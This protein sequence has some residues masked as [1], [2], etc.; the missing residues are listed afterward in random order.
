LPLPL[1]I[2]RLLRWQSSYQAAAFRRMHC[3][4]KDTLE[5][6]ARLAGKLASGQPVD[7][8]SVS[9]MIQ[10][11][12]QLL[13]LPT[14]GLFGIA[15]IAKGLATDYEPTTDRE[16]TRRTISMIHNEIHESGPMTRETAN[17]KADQLRRK[18]RSKGLLKDTVTEKEFESRVWK[19]EK[20]L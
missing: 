10:S 19:H 14:G 5:N 3:C 18:L 7:T 4:R 2:D 6:V 11:V 16:K 20:E 13:G 1:F 17:S 9:R 12:T 8:A 15:R